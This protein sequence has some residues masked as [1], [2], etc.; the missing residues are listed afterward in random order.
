MRVLYPSTWANI[1]FNWNHSFLGL[2]CFNFDSYRMETSARKAEVIY[3]KK[4][5]TP[6][7]CYVFLGGHHFSFFSYVYIYRF[8][9]L[10]TIVFT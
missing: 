7:A 2:I 10:G 8:V 4:T 6:S 5:T 9:Q 1:L 3:L